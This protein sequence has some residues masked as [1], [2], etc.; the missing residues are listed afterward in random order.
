MTVKKEITRVAN[1]SEIGDYLISGNNI[2][3][4]INIDDMYA[5]SDEECIVREEFDNSMIVQVPAANN[6]CMEVPKE[7]ILKRIIYP[8]YVSLKPIDD[9]IADLIGEN[10]VEITISDIRKRLACIPIGE[11]ERLRVAYGEMDYHKIASVDRTGVYVDGYIV[12]N[13]CLELVY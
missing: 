12:P 1:W 10:E 11:Y 5:I 8:R 2:G 9:V 4:W 3:H 6:L 13:E 7:L